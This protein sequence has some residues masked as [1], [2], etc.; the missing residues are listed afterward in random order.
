MCSYWC[1][2]TGVYSYQCVY[3]MW[4]IGTGVQVLVYRYW[5]IHL[6]GAGQFEFEAEELLDGSHGNTAGAADEPLHQVLIR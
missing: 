4:C 2:V 1:I 5:F 6:V 3:S